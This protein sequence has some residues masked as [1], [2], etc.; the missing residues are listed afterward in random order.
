[1]IVEA[2]ID[3]LIDDA[4]LVPV[5]VNYEKLVDGNFA[6]EQMGMP[7]RKESFMNA[8]SSIWKILNSKFGLMRIDFNEPF[9]LKELVKTFK[10][11]QAE[12]VTPTLPGA[13]KLLT[14]PSAT[15]MYGIEVID[16]HRVL[17][18]NIA[19]H[20]VFDSSCATSVMSTNAI[21]FSPAP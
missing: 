9:S 20:L 14:G 18:D 8:M 13:R 16:K 4:I 21:A 17:V 15:S 6:H 11:R 7:K 19:R 3:G 1:M 12:V 5:S 10:E 2:F